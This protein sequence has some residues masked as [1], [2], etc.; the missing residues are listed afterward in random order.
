MKSPLKIN[1]LLA[2]SAALITFAI[3]KLLGQSDIAPRDIWLSPLWLPG[4]AVISALIGVTAVTVATQRTELPLKVRFVDGVAG[5][6]AGSL[7]V[8]LGLDPTV[9]L[10][11][12]LGWPS[13]YRVLAIAVSIA[14][15]LIGLFLIL[16]LARGAR[17]HGAA[18]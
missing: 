18:V 5:A 12:A 10:L 17:S 16:I 8:V 4:L 14:L 11:K 9:V 1:I 13:D 2:L 7:A 15:L 3:R 6:L